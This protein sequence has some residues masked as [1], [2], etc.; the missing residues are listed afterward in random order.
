MDTKSGIPVATPVVALVGR[1]NVGKSTLFNRLSRTHQSLVFDEEGVTRDRIYAMVDYQITSDKGI[2]QQLHFILIDTP[3]LFFSSD[4]ATL[5]QQQTLQ[6]ITEA[7]L[8]LLVLDLRA[9]LLATDFRLMKAIRVRNKPFLLVLNKA[10]GVDLQTG[11]ADF[12][13][14]GQIF[15]SVS[16]TQGQGITD[17][18]QQISLQ[19]PAV[20]I[21]PSSPVPMPADD[22]ADKNGNDR[23]ATD[24][25][26]T[27]KKITGKKIAANHP[28]REKDLQE[29]QEPGKR[30]AIKQQEDQRRKMVVAVIG[31]PNVG[32]SSL[33][34]RLLGEERVLT[35]DYPG[36]TRDAVMI[37][38][39]QDFDLLDTAGVRRRK[40]VREVIEKLAVVKAL[41]A[42]RSADI[43]LL[44]LD[45]TEGIVD[46]D[47]HLLS[48]A[49]DS[50]RGLV[51][52]IN[53]WDL[54]SESEQK[55]CKHDI[56][57][58]LPFAAYAQWLYLSARTGRN[59]RQIL[60]ALQATARSLSGHWPT[61]FLTE[62]LNQFVQQHNLPLIRGRRI[63]LRYAHQ[64]AALP[65]TI[66][67]HGNQV[68]HVPDAYKRYLIN[69]FQKQ[70]GI[71][72]API[73]LVLK[74]GENPYAHKTNKL[75]PR[76]IA[77]KRRLMR[78]VKRK[79]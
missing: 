52:I 36:T 45:A 39:N 38:W 75:T 78:F 48:F 10:D 22:L 55:Q 62:C 34:N 76:Q 16:A 40:Q 69:S 37:P 11:L 54:L 19:L 66:V 15:H 72:G 41:Q 42:I 49:V 6:A 29:E 51:V 23:K 35:C 77:K 65:L 4:L 26:V 14:I 5:A 71:S 2:T 8:I 63:K 47:L 21:P 58:R 61:A 33:V 70:L 46:Q 67:V 64:G 43:V 73:K 59:C 24:K 44:L 50:G 79:K 25:Q 7:D 13:P 18:L 12:Y 30:G 20:A 3:G 1:A 60:P 57:R 28:A 56:Q 27:S 74:A 9:G 32:K 17:L 68:E 53:K 31:R